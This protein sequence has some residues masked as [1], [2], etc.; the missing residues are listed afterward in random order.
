[1]F[2]SLIWFIHLI[3][4][5]IKLFPPVKNIVWP[6]CTPLHCAWRCWGFNSLHACLLPFAQ[7]QKMDFHSKGYLQGC[8]NTCFISFHFVPFLSFF[9][10][11]KTAFKSFSDIRLETM[12]GYRRYVIIFSFLRAM[13]VIRKSFSVEFSVIPKC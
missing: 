9:K 13:G 4:F 11:Q 6:S 10:C 5:S 7:T 12:F 3:L 2:L 1:M 8:K